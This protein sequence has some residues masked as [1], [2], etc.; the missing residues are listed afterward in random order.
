VTGENWAELPDGQK[1]DLQGNDE[2]DLP[3]GSIFGLATP[4]GGGWGA[5]LAQPHGVL[6]GPQRDVFM[7]LS[8]WRRVIIL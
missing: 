8:K 7:Q 1:V 4:G 5:G 2:I 3:A 6:S